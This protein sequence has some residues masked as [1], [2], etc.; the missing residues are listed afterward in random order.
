M[1]VVILIAILRGPIP[2]GLPEDYRQEM[3]DFVQGIS[4]YAK[5]SNPNFIV[6]P[7]NGHELLT[8]SGEETGV[9]AVTYLNAIDGVGREDL[10]YGYYDDDVATP[11]SKRDHML[12]FMDIAENS[13]IEVLVTDYCS[14]RSFVNDSYYRSAA[15]GYISFAAE[16]Q[17]LDS[18]PEYP[19]NP[20]NVNASNVNS[21]TEAKN[22][23]YLINPS[24]FLNKDAY[25]DAIKGTNYDIIIIDLFY[26]DVVLIASEVTSLRVKANGGARLIIAYMSI[27]EAEDYRYYWQTEWETNPPSWLAEENPEWPG[28]YKVRYWYEDWQDIIYGGNNSYLKKILD[29]GF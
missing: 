2:V 5:G 14:T 17:E 15:R 11:I 22:F 16:H 12:S 21:L 13:G 1:A 6:I 18:I 27:G 24:S 7:Q 4:A 8:E 26:N 19:A 10:F 23:L 25:F 9:P 20:Y 29:A 3:R 28:N